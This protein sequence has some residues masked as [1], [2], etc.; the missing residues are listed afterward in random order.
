M[1]TFEVFWVNRVA[2]EKPACR[3][4]KNAS[5]VIIFCPTIR[6]LDADGAELM[7]TG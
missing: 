6:V 3:S 1:K 7:C 2:T 5:F 4:L